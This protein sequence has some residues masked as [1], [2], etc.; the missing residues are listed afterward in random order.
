MV[1]NIALG[2]RNFKIFGHLTHQGVV[3]DS[4]LSTEKIDCRCLRIVNI[5]DHDSDAQSKFQ[6]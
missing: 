1:H 6:V 5:L 2:M 4:A 3:R